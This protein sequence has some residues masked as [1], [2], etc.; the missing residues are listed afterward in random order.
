MP[1]AKRAPGHIERRGNSFRI[2]LCVDGKLH[3]FTARTDD[4]RVAEDAAR[5]R[6]AELEKHSERVRDGLPV[7]RRFSDLVAHVEREVLPAVSAGTRRSYGDSLKPLRA[8]FLDTRGDPELARIRAADIMAY[9]S[10]RRVHRLGKRT[11]TVHNR[12]LAK[13]RAVLH[14]LFA[15]AER[16]EWR[17][18]NPV[19]ATDAP[20]SD[21][22][23]YCILTDKQYEALV[24]A[25]AD[26]MLRAYVLVLGETGLRCESEALW[27]QWEDLNFDN[28]FVAVR[29]GRD[30]HRTKSGRTRMVPMTP[31]LRQAL[32]EHRLR[33]Q[34][35]RYDGKASPWVFHHLRTQA[36]QHAGERIGSLRYA[37]H[38]A[39]GRAKLPKELRQHDLRHRRVTEWL[40]LGKGA[41]LVREAMGHSSIAVTERYLHLVPSHLT[42]LVDDL[43]GHIAARA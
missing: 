37:F 21:P 28:G 7:A 19:A 36:R 4:R 17:D 16:M 42:A 2:T 6:Y 43:P 15:L 23:P 14:R 31:V 27:L 41:A 29:S 22:H 40:R 34:A 33:Y 26:P 20:K 32:V 38:V 9:L 1:R 5:L 25:C 8:Y 30:D 13:D 39:A 11:E 10:W 18:G 12:T 3:R 35:A 24:A